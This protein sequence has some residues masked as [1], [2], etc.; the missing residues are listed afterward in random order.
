MYN[1]LLPHGL[2]ELC[3]YSQLHLY[4]KCIFDLYINVSYF[5]YYI[6][7]KSFHMLIIFPPV[8][9]LFKVLLCFY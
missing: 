4:F 7:Y 3:S 9:I 8:F 2:L 5:K 1:I 6:T